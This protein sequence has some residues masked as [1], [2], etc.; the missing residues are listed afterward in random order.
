MAI[1]KNENDKQHWKPG[2]VL[3][4]VPVVMVSCGYAP[5]WKPN[6]ITIA[7]IGNVCSTPPMLSISLRPE[8]HSC[9]IIKATGEFVVNIPTIKL[10]KI[11]DWC[12]MVSGRTIDKFAES[13]LNQG[14]STKVKCPIIQECAINIECQVR[15]I[16]PLGSHTMFVAEV[17]GVQVSS[18]H[19]DANG[20]LR[21]DKAGL[22]AYCLGHYFSLGRV[23]DHF[24][25]SIR[26]KKT[27][28]KP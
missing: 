24:G 9:D 19:I 23:I 10:S 5:I 22:I 1:N 26:K 15:H 8:R 17:L 6:I 11:T 20:K 18:Q 27:R 7:W 28:R 16:L 21:L 13:G 25:Y 4:P 2:N 14:A 3:T 12:G